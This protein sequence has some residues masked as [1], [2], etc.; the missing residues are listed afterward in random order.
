[1][2]SELRSLGYNTVA[3][4]DGREALSHVE[5]GER[6]DLLF[7][8]VIMPGGMNGPQLADEVARRHPGTRVLYTSA[9][10]ENAIVHHGRLDEGVL[11]LSKPYRK[12]QL[13]Q[14]VRLA[15]GDSVQT[16]IAGKNRLTHQTE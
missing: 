12:A 3:A 15:L 14:M 9:Y 16:E 13:A 7:T 2:I 4:C 11:L 10:T 1:V 5:S 8:D 6:F